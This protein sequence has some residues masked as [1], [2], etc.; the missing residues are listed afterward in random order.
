MSE[1][2]RLGS[3]LAGRRQPGLY[4]W[5]SRAHP[6]AVRRELAG[7]GWAVHVLDGRGLVDRDALLDGLAQALSFPAWYGRNWDALADCLSDL[8]WL[9]G[10]GQVLLWE[11]YGVLARHDPAA[12]LTVCEVLAHAGPAVPFY[13]LL[14]G[15]GPAAVDGRLI[16]RL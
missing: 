9:P 13:V 14:R 8:S 16:P 15:A 6:E 5:V 4:R 10:Q 11:R 12:W 3:V 7:A 1:R 2:E